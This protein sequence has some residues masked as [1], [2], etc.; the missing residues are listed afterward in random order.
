MRRGQVNPRS[1]DA[2][3]R[4]VK[5]SIA[6]LPTHFPVTG[7]QAEILGAVGALCDELSA[8]R[9]L[10]WVRTNRE[11]ASKYGISERTVTNW[12]RE[13]CPFACGQWSVLDWLA[14]RRYAPAGAREKFSRHLRVRKNK[15]PWRAV[16]VALGEV[17]DLKLLYM[18]SGLEAPDWMRGFRASRRKVNCPQA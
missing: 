16:R 11:L 6:E 15:S 10:A 18:Q 13:G 1:W 14:R 8:R 3:I 4:A 9:H 7:E 12:R 2:A 5:K 17:R